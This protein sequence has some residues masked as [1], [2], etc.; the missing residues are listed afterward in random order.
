MR[1]FS[2]IVCSGEESVKA[3]DSVEFFGANIGQLRCPFVITNCLTY[4]DYNTV[5]VHYT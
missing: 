2:S 1:A 5:I 3:V 4:N